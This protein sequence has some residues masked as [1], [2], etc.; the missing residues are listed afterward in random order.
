VSRSARATGEHRGVRARVSYVG[1]HPA[2][3]SGRDPSRNPVLPNG[4]GVALRGTARSLERQSELRGQSRMG[5]RSRGAA[6]AYGRAC[7]RWPGSAGPDLA[8]APQRYGLP[9]ESNQARWRSRRLVV[10]TAPFG[11]VLR[12]AVQTHGAVA[13]YPGLIGQARLAAFKAAAAGC[14]SARNFDPPYCLT[15]ECYRRRPGTISDGAVAVA[16]VLGDRRE[17]AARPQDRQHPRWLFLPR[18]LQLWS[19]RSLSP[20]PCASVP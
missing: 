7:P 16:R 19:R 14:Q 9:S 8:G 12:P 3:R 17:G 18:H 11:V 15:E 20:P 2:W 4:D 5:R 13:Q 1:G 6:C 10:A